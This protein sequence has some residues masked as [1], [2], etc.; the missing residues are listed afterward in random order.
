M[1]LKTYIFEGTVRVKV[2]DAINTNGLDASNVN[3]LT[4]NVRDRMQN[5]FT[6]LNNNNEKSK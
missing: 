5:V 2:L 3:E 1:R 4:T 6:E